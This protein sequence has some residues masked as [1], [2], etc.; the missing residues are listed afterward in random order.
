[1]ITPY[2]PYIISFIQ[3][4]GLDS[5]STEDLISSCCGLIGDLITSF[6]ASLLELVETEAISNVLTKGRRCK[7][8][9]RKSLAIWATREI[10][11]LKNSIQ[12]AGEQQ[13]AAAVARAHT[14]ESLAAEQVVGASAG[15]NNK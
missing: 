9:K 13:A 11:K 10:K 4:V 12:S 8:S 14:S 1:M 6:G 5:I 7:M 3:H 15:L 2:V